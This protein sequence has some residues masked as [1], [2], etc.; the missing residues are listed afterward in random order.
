MYKIIDIE[1]VM[2]NDINKRIFQFCFSQVVS[3]S[4]S[5]ISLRF[6]FFFLRPCNIIC[7]YSA[8]SCIKSNM[9]RLEINNR[10]Q[11]YLFSHLFCSPFSLSFIFPLLYKRNVTMPSYTCSRAHTLT[12][13]CSRSILAHSAS[14]D[15]SAASEHLNSFLMR[16]QPHLMVTLRWHLSA[17]GHAPG[18]HC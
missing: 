6:F 14:H 8:F 3:S 10:K 4:S 18:W 15:T 7:R 5:I 2:K 13:S 16:R 1:I 11:N 12:C 17:E 9:P